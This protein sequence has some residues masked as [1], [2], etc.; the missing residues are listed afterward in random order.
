MIYPAKSAA[1]IA[2]PGMF[3]PAVIDRAVEGAI[4]VFASPPGYLLSDI[5]VATLRANGRPILWLRTDSRDR[6][7]A[8]FLLSI[9][10]AARQLSPSL[11]FSTLEEMQKRP[12][13][14]FGWP[15]LFSRLGQEMAV[16]ALNRSKN[17]LELLSQIASPRQVV[18]KQ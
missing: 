7:P 1:P 15:P 5:L 14:I 6:D 12:G 11:G 13:P 3:R 4:T 10:G 16:Q 2:E 17:S 8:G 18:K 9:V